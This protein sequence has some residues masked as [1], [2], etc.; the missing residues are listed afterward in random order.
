M[1]EK[2]SNTEIINT[3]PK[4][5]CFVLM[6]FSKEFDDVYQIGIKESCDNGGAYCERVDEQIFQEA[7]IER[8]YNQI[9]KADFIVADMT[10]RNPN[11]FYEVGYAH[12]L[13]KSTVLLTSNVEDIPSDLRHLPHIVYNDSLIDL[14]NKLTRQVEWFVENPPDKYKESEIDIELFCEGVNLSENNYIIE[15]GMF[16]TLSFSKNVT[17]HNSGTKTIKG[18]SY[19]FS[20]L[21][22]HR[23]NALKRILKFDSDGH[24]YYQDMLLSEAQLPDGSYQYT[25][26]E[27]PTLFAGE[28]KSIFLFISES[29]SVHDFTEKKMTFKILTESG[30]REYPVTF[31]AVEMD[32]FSLQ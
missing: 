28:Y 17:L 25:E 14:R 21:T 13:G 29:P 20:A 27:N 2:E 12:A 30:K 5:F 11:V 1:T 16:A 26:N 18:D 7:F 31:K 9:S 15:D 4:P 3:K 32:D 23:C 24:E 10:G 6:P 22:K 8:I 19:S